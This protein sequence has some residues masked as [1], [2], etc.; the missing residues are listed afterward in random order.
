[1]QIDPQRWTRLIDEIARLAAANRGFNA[2]LSEMQDRRNR[3]QIELDLAERAAR[4]APPPRPR[5]A[6]ALQDSDERRQAELEPMRAELRQAEAEM[7][8]LDA[9]QAAAFA[10]L[11]ALRRLEAECR[12]WASQNNIALPGDPPSPRGVARMQSAPATAR[13]FAM[14]QPGVPR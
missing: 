3:L 12:A 1:M 5:H 11:S 2:T 8:R 14:P 6:V 9:S 7:G 13:R 10:R 4:R